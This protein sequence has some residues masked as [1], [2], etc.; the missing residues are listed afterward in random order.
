MLGSIVSPGSLLMLGGG[1]IT[2]F[3]LLTKLLVQ[4]LEDNAM[5]FLLAG[6]ETTSTSLALMSYYLALHPE[7]QEKLRREVDEHFPDANEVRV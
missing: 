1:V 5:L 2:F 3:L 7:I 4:E 6:F